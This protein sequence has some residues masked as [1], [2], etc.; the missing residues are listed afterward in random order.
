M[1]T[2][3][4]RLHEHSGIWYMLTSNFIFTCCTFALKLIPADMFDIMIVRFLIQSIIFGVFTIFYKHYNVFDTNGQP[5]ACILNILMSNGT[6]LF[7]LAAF[8]F[9][10]L[11]DVNTIKYTYIVWAAILAV[12]FLKERFKIVN[13]I[14]LFLTFIGLI[15]T[16]KP[17][18]FMKTLVHIFVRILSL[19]SSSSVLITTTITTTTLNTTIATTATS[20]SYYYLG[21]GLAFLS[22]L[23]K[24]IQVIARKQLLITKQPHSVMNLQFTSTALLILLIYSIIRRFWQPES[25]PWKWMG[26]V[27]VII[28]FFQLLAIIFFAKALKRENIQLIAIISSLDIVYAVLLQYIFFGETK[29]WIFYVGAFL[30]VL[31]AII[32]SVDYH[33][34]NEQESKTQTTHDENRE[35]NNSV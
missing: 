26:T 8:Y 9:V 27:G 5:V 2:I 23:A 14:S 17:H 12:V 31:S 34:T 10:P 22:A 24:A 18:F 3:R 25:Y 21:I 13:A 6:N 4:R 15:L 29:S 32:L 16:T 30:V 28:A 20:S 35:T 1:K 7:Y 19:S 11:S 33:V